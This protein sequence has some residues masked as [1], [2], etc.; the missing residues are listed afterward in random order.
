MINI[1]SY[2]KDRPAQLDLTLSSFKTYFKEW[3]EQKLTIIYT[4]S[5]DFFKQGYDLVKKYHPE[6]N[7]IKETNFRLDTLNSFNSNSCEYTSWLMDDD[8]FINDFSLDTNTFKR[9]KNDELIACI[10]PRLYPGVNFCFTQN[11]ESPKPN[12]IEEN[13]WNWKNSNLKGD[14]EYPMSLSGLHIF[15]TSDLKFL[16]NM[17]F[18]GPN[19]LEGG[20][21][22]NRPQNRPLMICFNNQK[23]FCVCV[24]KVQIENSNHSLNTHSIESLNTIFLTGKR[25]SVKANDKVLNSACHGYAKIIFE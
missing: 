16:N 23:T 10:S 17:Y 4:Y 12:F 14:W 18:K 22:G 3:S 6:F 5:N 1:I 15:R 20:M 24:N 13:I 8:I 7:W 2:S 19:S 25:L 11:Y 21:D 9:F